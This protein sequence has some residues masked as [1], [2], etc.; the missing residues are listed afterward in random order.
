[1]TA[2]AKMKNEIELQ[3]SQSSLIVLPI[4]KS[5]TSSC[6]KRLPSGG[7]RNK[8]RGHHQQ[9]NTIQ[10]KNNKVPIRTLI[11]FA[12]FCFCSPL[13]TLQRVSISGIQ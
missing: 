13:L 7:T 3:G 11:I 6:K 9:H 1:M 8:T 2:C 4:C 12:F 10:N 5:I